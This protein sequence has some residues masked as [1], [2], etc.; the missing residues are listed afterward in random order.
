MRAET[1]THTTPLPPPCAPLQAEEG[2]D[3]YIAQFVIQYGYIVCFAAA[4][5]ALSLLALVLNVALL[6]V[7][8]FRLLYVDKRTLPSASSPRRV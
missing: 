4:S 3:D 6:R 2:F 8:V 5:P 7:T 1:H